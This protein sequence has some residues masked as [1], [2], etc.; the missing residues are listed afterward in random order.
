MAKSD[1]DRSI[2]LAEDSRKIADATKKD[3]SV[4]RVISASS[5]RDGSSMKILAALT[6]FFLPATFLA[7]RLQLSFLLAE[8]PT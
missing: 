7:V 8:H 1:F 5:K 4:M 6:M 3:S 2:G